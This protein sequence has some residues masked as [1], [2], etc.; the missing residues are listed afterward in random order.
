MISFLSSIGDAIS[1]FLD[2]IV[3]IFQAIVSVFT[4]LIEGFV[5]ITYCIGLLPTFLIVFAT[6]GIMVCVIL[7]LIGR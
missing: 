5:F 2:V 7:H 4:M 1:T 3:T 6:A